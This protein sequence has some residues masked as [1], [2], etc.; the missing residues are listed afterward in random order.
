MCQ[1]HDSTLAVVGIVFPAEGHLR[2]GH[3]GQ[4]VIRDRDAMCIAG[5]VLK[6][7]FRPAEGLLGVHDPILPVQRS[8][9]SRK[10]VLLSQ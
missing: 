1:R 2:I 6:H 5:Q 9:E 7:M 10:R 4:S 3:V 8:Q